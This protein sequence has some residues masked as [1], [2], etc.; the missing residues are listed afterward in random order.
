MS[1]AFRMEPATDAERIGTAAFV[2]SLRGRGVSDTAVLRALETVPRDFFAPRRFAD[3]SR[4]DVA[5]PLACGQTMTAPATV[6]QMLVAL[7]V[8]PGQR[9]L[10]IGTGSGY[11]TALLARLGGQVRSVERR[12]VLSEGASRRLEAA[13]LADAV[14]LID[15]DGLEG[16]P[17]DT[18]YDRILLNGVVPAVPSALTSRLLVG[19]RLVGATATS[20]APRL[21]VITRGTDGSLVHSLGAALRLSPLVTGDAAR[22]KSP[23][24]NGCL[25]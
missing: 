11:V 5:L 25:T 20:G 9:V 8:Q 6:A 7:H 22:P 19:G 16:L 13:G 14:E 3:L 17:D 24:L 21:L 12:S 15:G 1:V 23:A 18:H 10:E 2:L 4:S